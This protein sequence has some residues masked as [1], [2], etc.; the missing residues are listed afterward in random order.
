MNYIFQLAARFDPPRTCQGGQ[1]PSGAL[2]AR[3]R[4][5]IAVLLVLGMLAMTLALAYA[6]LRG[7]ATVAKLAENLGRGEA[8]RM[9]AESGVFSALRKM[10]DGSWAG[11]GTPLTG[12]LSDSSWYEVSFATGDELIKPGQPLYDEQLYKGEYAYRVTITST[13]YANDPGQPDVRAI[14]KIDAVVQLA[15]RSILAEPTNWSTLTNFTVHQW[16]DRDITVQE[17]VR[18]NGNAHLL[19]HLRLSTEYPPSGAPQ[20]AYLSGLN[21]MRLAGRGDQPEQFTRLGR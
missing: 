11:I 2:G 15:R 1:T 21:Q 7:Q 9:A 16:G 14:H 3:S 13:G 5:G 10:S 17:P 6:S 19:G 20:N 12:N 4:R 8:A 18:V